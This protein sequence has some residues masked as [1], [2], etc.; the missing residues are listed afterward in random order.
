[1]TVLTWRALSS[2]V[3]DFPGI[4]TANSLFLFFF[5]LTPTAQHFSGN[6][7]KVLEA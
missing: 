7:P 4:F 6:L 5:L 3:P 2:Q 1:M